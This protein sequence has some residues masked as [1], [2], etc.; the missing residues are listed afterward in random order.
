VVALAEEQAF[1][2]DEADQRRRSTAAG[3]DLVDLPAFT[4]TTL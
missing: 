2:F 4:N 1:D 3:V